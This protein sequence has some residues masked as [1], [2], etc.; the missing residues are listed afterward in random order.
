MF[1]WID[2]T[3]PFCYIAM[4]R[5]IPLVKD[6]NLNIDLEIKSFLLNPDLKR[7]ED[8]IKNLSTKY[9]IPYLKAEN[10]TL[11]VINLAREDNINFTKSKFINIYE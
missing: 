3:C 7:K 1:I 5:L 6:S 2:F 10:M 11:E 9:N 4:K 8:Y